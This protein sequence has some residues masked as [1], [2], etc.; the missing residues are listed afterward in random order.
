M[1]KLPKPTWAKRRA[2]SSTLSIFGVSAIFHN[3]VCGSSVLLQVLSLPFYDFT[4]LVA[5]H[6]S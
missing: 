4:K 3:T 6:I 2:T 5:R 1:T